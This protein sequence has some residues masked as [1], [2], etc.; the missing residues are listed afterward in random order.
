MKT[1]ATAARAYAAQV[2]RLNADSVESLSVA[3]LRGGERHHMFKIS[4]LGGESYVV[5]INHTDDEYDREKAGREAMALSYLDDGLAPRLYDYEECSSFFNRPA[6]F[7]SFLPGVHLDLAASS[8]GIAQ[9][10]R[11]DCWPSP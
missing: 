1:S 10:A 7:I 9:R 8:E 5:R 4:E 2:L 3:N 11:T 6:M